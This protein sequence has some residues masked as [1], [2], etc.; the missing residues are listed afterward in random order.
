MQR[1]NS[2]RQVLY[3]I[4]APPPVTQSH[5]MPQTCLWR[6]FTSHFYKG[7]QVLLWVMPF[8]FPK[9]FSFYEVYPFMSLSTPLIALIAALQTSTSISGQNEALNWEDLAASLPT[10]NITEEVRK[11]LHDWE[12]V[13]PWVHTVTTSGLL[14]LLSS[15]SCLLIQDKSVAKRNWSPCTVLPSIH[16]LLFDTY[17]SSSLILTA[18]NVTCRHQQLTPR[19]ADAEQQKT[20]DSG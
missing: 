20:E 18:A 7:Y 6:T 19:K 3:F 10:W 1:V 15:H 4:P 17:L 12:D 2:A 16:N 11:V 13:L 8:S 5:C 9:R 14:F